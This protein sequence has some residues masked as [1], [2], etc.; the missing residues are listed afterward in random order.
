VDAD[1]RDGRPGGQRAPPG[2]DGVAP[3]DLPYHERLRG[4][5]AR[6]PVDI[7][8]RGWCDILVRTVR[9][10]GT[11]NL[12]LITAGVTFYIFLAL[13]P[14]AIA[15]VTFY[16]LVTDS[17]TL[18]SHVDF[19]EGYVP[20]QAIAWMAAEIG[21]IRSAQEGG[22]SF[23]LAVSVGLSFWAMNNAVVALF[24]AMNI[25]Y[26]EEEK[27]STPGLYLR[28]FAFTFAAL[29]VGIA[30]VGAIVLLPLL[31]PA[32]GVG[33]LDYGGRRV[34]APILFT[35]VTLAAAVIYHVGPSRRPARWRWVAVGALAA[36]AGWL[37]AAI[38]LSWYLSH[39]ANYAVM[40]GSVG[41]V[42][43]LMFWLYISVYILLTGAWLN[44]E[45]ER[46]TMIDTTVGTERPLG[47][48]GAH[49]AD[50]VGEAAW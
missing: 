38:L 22:L 31:T 33:A 17:V 8:W 39:V 46:Q 23:T 7:G 9:R 48:R 45:I 49:V 19:L 21:R 20:D 43:A 11:D 1:A 41:T 34:T 42:V 24:G 50:T 25:A 36:A 30:M 6:N 18:D 3:R 10:I 28:C 37:A 5:A 13:V 35:I 14:A 47:K 16:G 32:D 2:L 27:R 40:Y 12:G 29:V 26:G 4:R 44:A 15:I